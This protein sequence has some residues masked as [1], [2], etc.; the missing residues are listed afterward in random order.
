MYVS[1][2][3]LICQYEQMVHKQRVGEGIL[4]HKSCHNHDLFCMFATEEGLLKLV[5][6]Q[7]NSTM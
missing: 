3:Y 5:S 1:G 6:L 4:E 7:N 2:N